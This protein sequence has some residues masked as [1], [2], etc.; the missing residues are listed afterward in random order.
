MTLVIVV[1]VVV[2]VVIVVVIVEIGSNIYS[3]S[4][5]SNGSRSDSLLAGIY[6]DFL[7]LQ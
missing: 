5:S 1:V 3:H 7:I 2:V 4:I 6:C